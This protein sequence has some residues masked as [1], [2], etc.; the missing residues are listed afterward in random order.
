LGKRKGGKSERG[1][2]GGDSISVT[3][4]DAKDIEVY[5][6]SALTCNVL[7]HKLAPLL[8]PFVG[9]RFCE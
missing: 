7:Q 6:V 1:G 9:C 8:V 3:L 2:G 5:L 4:L